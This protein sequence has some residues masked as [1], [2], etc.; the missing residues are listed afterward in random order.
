MLS[1]LRSALLCGFAFGFTVVSTNVF[2]QA[3]VEN[4]NCELK[5]PVRLVITKGAG[6]VENTYLVKCVGMAQANF[7]KYTSNALL[8]LSLDGDSN[9]VAA[10]SKVSLYVEYGSTLVNPPRGGK[11]QIDEILDAVALTEKVNSPGQPIDLILERDELKVAAM[12]GSDWVSRSGRSF[13]ATWGT[14]NDGIELPSISGDRSSIPFWFLNFQVREQGANPMLIDVFTA[15]H[16][17]QKQF[18]T[19]NAVGENAT[20]NQ[21]TVDSTNRSLVP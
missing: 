14:I 10:P 16:K 18:Y 2:A 8:T 1:G 7:N 11:L 4:Q 19:V 12:S 17:F 3:Q 21:V 13:W 15:N 20:V 9:G 5:R 6:E